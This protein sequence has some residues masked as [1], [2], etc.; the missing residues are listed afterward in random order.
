METRAQSGGRRP[1]G[2]G[3]RGFAI[4]CCTSYQQVDAVRKRAKATGWPVPWIGLRQIAFVRKGW[5]A[6][7]MPVDSEYVAHY[8]EAAAQFVCVDLT[9][10][11]SHL[12][13][14]KSSALAKNKP[15]ASIWMAST[16]AVV[17]A[18]VVAGCF[19]D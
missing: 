2:P 4:T 19:G 5:D 18:M 9:T 14:E 8:S 7:A 6:N 16:T 10:I 11:L 1:P 12:V 3:R 13:L 15:R 17:H